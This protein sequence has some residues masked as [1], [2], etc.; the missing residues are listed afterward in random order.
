MAIEIKD[1]STLNPAQ[2]RREVQALKKRAAYSARIYQQIGDRPIAGDA[3][4]Y[5]GRYVDPNNPDRTLYSDELVDYYD[6]L[7]EVVGED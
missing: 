3:H 7:V 2:M 6:A 1:L 5:K 4:I